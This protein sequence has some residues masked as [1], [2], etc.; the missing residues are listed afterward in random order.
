MDAVL[1][2]KTCNRCGEYK[3]YGDFY[4]HKAMSDGYLGQCK[5]CTKEGVHKYRRENIERIRKYDNGR[6]RRD[7]AIP[8]KDKYPKKRT[9]HLRVDAA[10]KSGKLKRPSSC[11]ECDK[12][13]K[14]LV[15]HHNDY[16]KVL[17]V[18]WMCELCHK[19]W[20]SKHGEGMNG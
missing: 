12:D 2:G 13:G 17:S 8:Y 15:A 18:V 9:A 7:G 10:L 1:S 6:P 19:S 14:R 3:P 4:K 5:E 11:S 16:S 20:H